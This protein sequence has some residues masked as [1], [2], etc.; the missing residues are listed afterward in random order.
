M[1]LKEDCLLL[2]ICIFFWIRGSSLVLGAN[3]FVT[4]FPSEV[5]SIKGDNVTLRCT[6]SISGEKATSAKGAMSWF[7][8]LREAA[9]VVVPGPRFSLI[10]PDTFLSAGEGLLVITNVSLEDAGIYTCQV[11][12]WSEGEM[13]ARPS[14]PAIFLQFQTSPEPK[15]TLLCNTNGFFPDAVVLTWY[16]LGE[17][18]PSSQQGYTDLGGS[19]QA[20]SSLELPNPDQSASYV[21]SVE[22]PS[23]ADP[24]R[25]QYYYEPC[26]QMDASLVRVL[27][28]LKIVM[29]LAIT[30]SFFTAGTV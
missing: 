24:L 23:L 28:L 12:L 9:S 1:A 20:S 29:I 2:G 19:F 25:A 16:R 30:A 7:K 13:R 10:Y 21:C 11:M 18:L 15:R 5:S 6:F 26:L 3:Y 14:H 22:H 17:K 27:N 8:G 4:Q